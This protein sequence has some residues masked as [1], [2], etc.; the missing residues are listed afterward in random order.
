[1]GPCDVHSGLVLSCLGVSQVEWIQQ[2]VVK[3]RIKRDYKPAPPR[4]LSSPAHS[5]AAQGN[6]FYNDA[7]WSSMWYIVSVLR[8]RESGL[9]CLFTAIQWDQTNVP[10][11]HSYHTALWGISHPLISEGEQ[12]LLFAC[13][14]S[15]C[16]SKVT[17]GCGVIVMAASSVRDSCLCVGFLSHFLTSFGF[18]RCSLRPLLDVLCLFKKQTN[19]RFFL[20][21]FK[22]FAVVC[23]YVHTCKHMHTNMFS[24][25]FYTDLQAYRECLHT[26]SDHC[27][28]SLCVSSLSN[29]LGSVDH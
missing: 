22:I 2:Q 19:K 18:K 11:A 5:S 4:S 21:F 15:G 27:S 9:L 17:G 20:L 28:F 23:V 13:I 26:P 12:T 7:K 16:R 24:E 10:H 3:R 6:V 1:M 29:V 25:L 8:I 14:Y